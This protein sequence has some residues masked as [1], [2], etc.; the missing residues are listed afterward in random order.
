MDERFLRQMRFE[1]DEIFRSSLEAVDPYQAVKRF[2]HVEKD[3]LVVGI[4]D[5]HR[6]ELDLTKYNRI[7]LV[8]A[9]KA[10]APMARAIEE[11]LG[12]R[13]H[14]GMI[15]VKYGFT[16]ELAVTEV[17]EAGHP[18]PDQRGVEGTKKIINFLKSAGEKDLIFSLISGGGSALLPQPAGEITLA[19]KQEITRRL[20]ACG[21][22]IDEINAVRK[23]IS[24]SKGGQMARA[25][26]PATI[27]N[28][29]LSDVVGDKVEVIASGPFTP[30]SSTFEKVRDVLR[31]YDLRDT[32]ATI[33][34][35][36][37]A[38][39]EGR[40]PETPKEGETIFDRVSN[41]VVGSNI[42]ALQAA[43]KKAEEFGYETLILSSM[44]EGE[45]R[46]VALVHSAIAK[47]VV[48]TG[49]PLPPP[50]CIISG[51]ETTVTIRGKGLG[52]RNQEFCL[53]AALDLAELPP[54]V[55]ILSGGTDGNDGPTDAAGAVVDPLTVKRGKEVGVEAL[56]FLDDNDAYHFF[57]KT[58]D[59]LLTGPT[60]TNVMD[61]RLVLV[62]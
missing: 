21:A 50:A 28:L 16:E 59:L 3:L 40:I 34:G 39:A 22:S 12:G 53:A 8:G 42:L 30:D 37:A 4:D 25:A 2:V 61:V 14:T 35:Y 43:A 19:E 45:T 49:R 15:N 1:A 32:P 57:E 44:I 58:K 7:S 31:R 60:N 46:E 13:L 6:V 23:H 62:R 54:R 38:G 33:Y 20:L 17:V 5:K 41:F 55:V 18:L 27:V 47:E 56:R 29:M 10:A 52:G 11:L 9:G 36:L 48:K 24:L 51:G 26:F